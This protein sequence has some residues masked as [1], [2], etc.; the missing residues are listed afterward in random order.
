[1]KVGFVG[2]GKMGTGMVHGL[3]RAG[4]EVSVYNRTRDKAEA[5]AKEGAQVAASLAEVCLDSE[6]VFT[7][8]SDDSAVESVAFSEG[9]L[10]SSLAGNAAHISSSTI[11]TAMARRLAAEHSRRG[12]AFLS[13]PVFGRPDVAETGK[14]LIVAGGPSRLVERLRPLF[15]AVGRQTFLAGAE[16]WQANALKLCGNFMIAGMLEAFGE[17]MANLRKAK[18]DPHLFVDTMSALFGSPVYANYGRIIADERFEPAGFE[19]RLGL[20]DIRLVLETAQEC[21]APMPMASLI[22]DHLLSEMALG[23]ANLDWS[24]ITKVSARNAGL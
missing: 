12:Q 20:K 9:G 7:M 13:A 18:V 24:G 4:H 8:L 14:L 22:R 16:P 19:L 15:E 3:L 6:A 5:L 23:H 11:S 1:M 21:E 10:A 17:A 2:L